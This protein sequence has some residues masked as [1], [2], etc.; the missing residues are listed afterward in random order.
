MILLVSSFYRMSLYSAEYGLT[1]LRFLVFGFLIFEAIGLIFTFVYIARPKFNIIA[2][3]SVI[4]LSYYLLLNVVPMDA[5]IARNQIDR[6][7]ATGGNGIEYVMNLSADAAEQV[8][9]LEVS[10]NPKTV[11]QAENFQVRVNL[12]EEGWRQW[13]LSVARASRE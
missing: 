7:F 10:D 11:L 1:R 5:I 6:Y 4:A 8:A 9:R 3:Y 2:I 13:N 12:R